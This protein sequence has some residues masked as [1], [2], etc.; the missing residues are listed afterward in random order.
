[1]KVAERV[2][3]CGVCWKVV[4]PRC[5]RQ[6]KKIVVSRYYGYRELKGRYEGAAVYQNEYIV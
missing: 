3:L 2:L 1:M 4:I 6:F 5:Y